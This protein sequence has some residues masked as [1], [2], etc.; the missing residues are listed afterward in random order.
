MKLVTMQDIVDRAPDL[1][2]LARYNGFGWDVGEEQVY[3]DLRAMPAPRDINVVN[4]ILWSANATYLTDLY[5]NECGN[6]D[7]EVAVEFTEQ[8]RLCADCLAQALALV[9]G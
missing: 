1:F 6:Y 4:A 8:F 7:C 3:N 5:C 9:H 2:R